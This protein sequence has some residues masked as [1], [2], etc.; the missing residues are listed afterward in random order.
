MLMHYV[1]NAEIFFPASNV[2]TFLALRKSVHLKSQN[3]DLRN[4]KE[5]VPRN[6]IAHWLAQ[7]SLWWPNMLLNWF[8]FKSKRDIV[9]SFF[10]KKKQKESSL[11][12]R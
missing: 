1:T 7:A 5:N 3:A 9:A 10:S 11:L 12:S 4:V 8:C 6:V 2:L